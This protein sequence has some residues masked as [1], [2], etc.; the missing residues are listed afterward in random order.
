MAKIQGIMIT[1]EPRREPHGLPFHS[2]RGARGLFAEG[3]PRAAGAALGLLLGEDREANRTDISF[4]NHLLRDEACRPHIN[5]LL[6]RQLE[7]F[8]CRLAREKH[9]EEI[10]E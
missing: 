10:L 9:G 8:P 2:R 3:K 4:V 5:A 7:V 6:L 1:G